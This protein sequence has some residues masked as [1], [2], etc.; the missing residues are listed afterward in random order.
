MVN[1]LGILLIIVGMLLIGV[2]VGSGL[3]DIDNSHTHED[4]DYSHSPYQ[5]DATNNLDSCGGHINLRTGHYH[6][7]E[8]PRC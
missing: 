4:R 8:T 5:T 7:H 2:D 6:Y 3:K 1:K